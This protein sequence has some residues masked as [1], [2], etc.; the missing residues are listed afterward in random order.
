[1]KRHISVL[2]LLA[3]VFIISVTSFGCRREETPDPSEVSPSVPQMY[4][5]TSDVPEV[6]DIRQKAVALALEHGLKE[7][8]LK[9]E[10]ELFLQFADILEKNVSL[11]KWKEFVY[12]IFPVVAENAELLDEGYFFSG[13]ADLSI[14]EADIVEGHGGE[15]YDDSKSILINDTLRETEPDD[16]LI[17]LFHELMHFVDYNL[18]GPEQMCYGLD[19]RIITEKEAEGLSEEEND[20]TWYIPDPAF[21]TEAGAELYTGKYYSKTV[22]SYF[23]IV[24]FLSGLDHI[25]G[26]DRT[27][28]MFFSSDSSYL[29]CS[30]LQKAGYSI[31]DI[32]EAV[33]SL[34]RYT[35]SY[36]EFPDA[37]MPIEDI[38]IDLYISEKGDDWK[39]DQT[40]CYIL[41][42]IVEMPY[43]GNRD[44]KYGKELRDIAF[45]DFEDYYRFE[46]EIK[47]QAGEDL[48]F[49]VIPPNLIY[50][51]G[52]PYLSARGSWKNDD[53]E[54]IRGV[55]L[56]EMDLKDNVLKSCELIEPELL[57]DIAG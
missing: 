35:N 12:R 41:K 24:E 55:I 21:I 36:Y 15:Y 4:S 27:E 48:Y 5:E 7:E 28:R 43:E 47:K 30:M 49:R 23:P 39:E 11:G 44:S 3:T 14:E 18:S 16:Y 31:E 25:Y 20:R 45:T 52:R 32:R 19:G 40:F 37:D 57:E 26:G 42:C 8:E 33:A 1:M 9:G 53:L 17:T 22:A 56:L 10:Y 2:M 46:D 6:P 29:F 34:S 54:E 51:D 13:L 50:I 38:L